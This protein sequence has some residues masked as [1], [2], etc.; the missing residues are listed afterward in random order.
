MDA[1]LIAAHPEFAAKGP[2]TATVIAPGQML[3]SVSS[4]QD[5]LDDG[6]DPVFGAFLHLLERDIAE[7]PDRLHLV[8]DELI[9]RVA[10]LSPGIQV[11]DDEGIPDDVTL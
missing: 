3:V 10:A 9:A 5:A 6:D 11:S 8:D 7:H 1:A 4:P 2:A